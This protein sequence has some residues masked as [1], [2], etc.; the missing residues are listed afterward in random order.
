MEHQVK[1]IVMILGTYHMANPGVNTFD[2]EADDVTNAKRQRELQQLVE[3]LARFKP[4]KIA[5]EADIGLDAKIETLYQD[6]LNGTYHPERSEFDQICLPLAKLMGH[7]KLYC[8]D[9]FRNSE[10]AEEDEAA[11]DV[12]TFAKANNQ[13]GL[14]EKAHAMGQALAQQPT[15]TLTELQENG[16]VIDMHR[17]LNQE[18]TIR[19]MH[20][21]NNTPTLILGQ[22]GTED[23]YIGL[24]WL[25][26]SYERNLKIYVNLTRITESPNER[27]LLIIGA[28]HTFSIQ[29]FLE[30]SRDYIVESPLKYLKTESTD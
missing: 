24:D 8:V 2:I 25:L 6:Y 10:P 12:E 7:P 3:Q 22:I 11:L 23:N 9:W 5:I 1:P 27:I 21:I 30:D 29:R 19:V 17:F 4:T 28:G 15:S 18:D 20:E 13:S 26:W 16:S 14:L